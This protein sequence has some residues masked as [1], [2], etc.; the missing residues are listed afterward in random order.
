M[1]KAVVTR[2]YVDGGIRLTAVHPD[3]DHLRATTFLPVP[4]TEWELTRAHN[5]LAEEVNELAREAFGTWTFSQQVRF[6]KEKGQHCPHCGM[7]N[8][9]H[10]SEHEVGSSGVI[11]LYAECM[12]CNRRWVEQY[13]LGGVLPI[14]KGKIDG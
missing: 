3:D 1:P 8:I 9:Y 7:Q 10:N 6:V 12:N 14:V 5:F 4:V 11:H 2:R 13:I